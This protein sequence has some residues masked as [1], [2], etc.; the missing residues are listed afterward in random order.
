MRRRSGVRLVLRWT[1]PLAWGLAILLT[2]ALWVGSYVRGRPAPI[3]PPGERWTVSIGSDDGVLRVHLLGGMPAYPA[4]VEGIA[5][6][7]QRIAWIEINEEWDREARN[8]APRLLAL[9]RRFIDSHWDDGWPI[10]LDVTR[11]R[12]PIAK[13][14]T[15]RLASGWGVTSAPRTWSLRLGEFVQV[16]T[17]EIGRIDKSLVATDVAVRYSVIVIA[18]TAVA[19]PV[20]FAALRRRVRAAREK[21]AGLCRRC[22]YNLTGNVTGR[23]SECGAEVGSELQGNTYTVVQSD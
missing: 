13:Q 22:G 20:W 1:V 3:V 6:P 19:S 9:R 2:A 12:P 21:R 8:A 14:R 15:W 16:A 5:D 7:S 23:C 17:Y 11:S 18:L 4:S 10:E